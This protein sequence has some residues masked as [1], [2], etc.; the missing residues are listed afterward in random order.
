MTGWYNIIDF[1]GRCNGQIKV[2]VKL[3]TPLPTRPQQISRPATTTKENDTVPV[4]DDEEFDSM[5]GRAL[6]RKFNELEGI[7]QRLKAR[8]FDVTAEGEEDDFDPDD[9]FEKDLNTVVEDEEE[10]NLGTDNFAWL[11][12]DQ[13]MFT[14][15]NPT[16][17]SAGLKPTCTFNTTALFRNTN[18]SELFQNILSSSDSFNSQQ[19]STSGLAQT[20]NV[21]N[22]SQSLKKT[23]IS[24]SDDAT[25]IPRENPDGKDKEDSC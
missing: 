17:S 20:I 3:L 6:K 8:L 2:Q 24:E 9:E 19:P 7:S 4:E 18:T 15:E 21:S 11:G 25:I 16:S 22:L 5:L 10:E 13:A 1:N 23:S 12:P 14:D